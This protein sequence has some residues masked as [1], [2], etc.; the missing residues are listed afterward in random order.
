[1]RQVPTFALTSWLAALTSTMALVA[2]PTSVVPGAS[3]IHRANNIASGPAS[4]PRTRRA[5]PAHWRRLVADA[6]L[7]EE[8]SCAGR[9]RIPAPLLWAGAGDVARD[10]SGQ[11]ACL[12]RL[13]RTSKSCMGSTY[14]IGRRKRQRN[15]VFELVVIVLFRPSACY[16]SRRI[17]ERFRAVFG[18]SRRSGSSHGLHVSRLERRGLVAFR[19][20][21]TMEGVRVGNPDGHSGFAPPR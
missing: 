16:G 14:A 1:M 13:N 12:A 21:S 9:R 6:Q 10:A 8:L 4:L 2:G 17:G 3:K 19:L 15:L 20:W 18:R 5:R 7:A 11:V